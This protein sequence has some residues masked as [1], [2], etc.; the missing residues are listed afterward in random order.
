MKVLFLSQGKLVSDHPGWHNALEKLKE[1]GEISDFQNI[2]YY[3]FADQFGWEAFYNHVINLCKNENYDLVYFHYFHGGKKQSPKNCI[4]SLKK[5]TYKPVIIVSA[6]DG[7]S[8]NWM[9]PDYPD[10][11]KDASRFADIT[12]STQMGKAADKMIKWG[13]N[14]VVYTPN[15]MCQVRFKAD[16]IDLS[17]H[18]FDFDIVFVG[19]NNSYR[20]FNPISKAWFGAKYRNRLVNALFKRYG[21]KF[22]LYGNGWTYPC[23]QGA[24]PF[25]EQ[26]NT[27][28]RGR[29]LVGGN[30]Y[31][32]SDYYSSN[33]VFFE[34]SS[35]IPT[36]EL[37][38]PRLDRVLRNNDHCYFALDIKAVIDRCDELL[39]TDPIKLYQKASNAAKYIEEKHTQYHRM[40]FKINTVKRYIKNNF[41]LD[42]EFPFFLPE[43]NL[44]EEKKFAIRR[45]R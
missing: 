29:I 13:A 5:I 39:N 33:R 2:P 35:G 23:A 45:S 9:R 32:H 1:E 38:V 40:K 42:V 44:E 14:N 4:E 20:L 24:I 41:E 17:F 25:N 30:P 28:R 37:A 3:S 16:S 34:I 31:S 11:F 19:S 36:V 7:F 10:D 18:Q 22:G 26:Q 27:F 12:F 8:D 15:S 21:C 43:V 6:G